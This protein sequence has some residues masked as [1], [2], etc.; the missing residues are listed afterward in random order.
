MLCPYMQH[1]LIIERSDLILATSRLMDQQGRQWD[2]SDETSTN[3]EH[4]KVTPVL[5]GSLRTVWVVQGLTTL[6]SH[7]FLYV[8]MTLLTTAGHP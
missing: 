3:V 5:Y 4:N 1:M 2:A 7:E 6:P 8:C